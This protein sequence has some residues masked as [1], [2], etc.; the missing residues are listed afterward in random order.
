MNKR[1][2]KQLKDN[3]IGLAPI[4]QDTADTIQKLA[5]ATGANAISLIHEAV[6]LLEKSLGRQL[7]VRKPGSKWDM[8][9]N[10]FIQFKTITE[11]EPKD[12]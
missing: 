5:D 4:D 6:K 11:F 7:I 10:K 9:I 12:R 1:L 2:V 3:N 8:K